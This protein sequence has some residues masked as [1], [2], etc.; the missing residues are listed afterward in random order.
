MPIVA[1]RCVYSEGGPTVGG[2]SGEWIHSGP[3]WNPDIL[4]IKYAGA[5]VRWSKTHFDSVVI[6][7]IVVTK[8]VFWDLRLNEFEVSDHHLKIVVMLPSIHG[9]EQSIVSF[10]DGDVGPGGIAEKMAKLLVSV[11]SQVLSEE[12]QYTIVFQ[13][14]E[15]SMAYEGGMSGVE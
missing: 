10:G 14:G 5:M 12:W 13:Q 6:P 9:A 8:H 15:K 3:E 1:Q 4:P 7:L 2:D 11:G